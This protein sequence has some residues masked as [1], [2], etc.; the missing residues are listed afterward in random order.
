[1]LKTRWK[2]EE[3]VSF[4]LTLLL[5]ALT[6]GGST[7]Q[8]KENCDA[9]CKNSQD[10]DFC[11]E[12]CQRFAPR[13]TCHATCNFTSSQLPLK[14]RAAL[15]CLQGCQDASESYLDGV[16][17]P[18]QP[19]VIKN[20]ISATK[21][22][23]TWR[24]LEDGDEYVLQARILS[25]GVAA[26]DWFDIQEMSTD[27][28]DAAD[29]RVLVVVGLVPYTEYQFRVA[30]KL[31]AVGEDGGLYS[32]ASKPVRTASSGTPSF[33]VLVSVRQVRK[34]H[35]NV[36]WRAPLEPRGPIT[37]YRLTI[38]EIRGG[39]ELKDKSEVRKERARTP[40]IGIV[41]QISLDLRCLN[42]L[43]ARVVRVQQLCCVM[44]GAVDK[45]LEGAE[46][47]GKLLASY[48]A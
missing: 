14:P 38:K 39:E 30:W 25:R 29:E 20:S 44:M 40:F 8:S 2:K 36:T 42:A 26:K 4:L 32:A 43:S 19:R 33:P 28:A 35:V 15:A 45:S 41:K 23:L 11:S 16:K 6:A 37:F 12:G 21:L 9:A 10:F 18:L 46:C 22:K 27:G 31:S 13:S 5:F 47:R 7:F 24:P 48:S 34:L 1:M 17:R 3:P